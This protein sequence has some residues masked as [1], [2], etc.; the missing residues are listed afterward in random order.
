MKITSTQSESVLRN[1]QPI[2]KEL[3]DFIDKPWSMLEIGSGNGQ[4]GIYFSKNID[5]LT[6]QLSDLRINHETLHRALK[7][8]CFPDQVLPPID[9]TIGVSHPKGVYDGVYTANT[10]HI[11]SADLIGDTFKIAS[12]VLKKG[13]LFFVYGP[14]KVAGEFTSLSNAHF[15]EK[16]RGD[17]SVR[18][19]RD[20][21]A[22]E[23]A[24]HENKM[25]LLKKID[26]PSYNFFIVFIKDYN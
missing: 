14:F 9:I 8:A 13:G 2:L 7:E 26:M 15:D 20:L 25:S 1:R 22:L 18:G 19:L 3:S 24:A 17:D 21:E 23:S 6:W 16:L 5:H 12:Q 10:F 4:H 11:M